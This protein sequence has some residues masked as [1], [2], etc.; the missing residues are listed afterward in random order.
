MLPN[1]VQF[2]LAALVIVIAGT[3]LTQFGDIISQRTKFGALLVGGILI[4]GATS[5][6]ELAIDLNAVRIGSPDL[7]AGDLFGSSLFNLLILAVLDLTHYS[8]GEMLSKSS[9]RHALVA[10]V[11]IILTALP[12]LFIFLAPRLGD[13]EILR[14]GPGSFALLIAYVMGVRLIYYRGKPQSGEETSPAQEAAAIHPRFS[15][16]GLKGAV[17]GFIIT[18][19]AILLAAPFLATAAHNLA[20][21][22]GLGGTFFGTTFVALC[23]ALPEIAT[24]LSAVRMKAFDLALGNI[25][26][27]NCFNMT[28]FIPMDLVHTGS[29][30]AAISQSHIYTALCVIV[31][32]C[33]VVLGQLSRV[34]SKKPFLD[35]DALLV[36]ALVLGSLT[37]L[38]FLS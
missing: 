23:T 4:A 10:S 24:T 9:A 3:A 38:Y 15:K 22:S 17:V 5:L 36:I 6:P 31:G 8:H 34:E 18:A 35:P 20:E 21:Q 32:T 11:S 33:A 29:I 13:F 25:L 19:L 14:L 16:L 12:A 1:L 7:A 28:I 2:A 30:F 26:G 27:S 37:G